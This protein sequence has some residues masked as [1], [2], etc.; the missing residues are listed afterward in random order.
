LSAQGIKS[1]N[2]KIQLTGDRRDST[3]PEARRAPPWQGRGNA[4]WAA[5]SRP[6][7]RGCAPALGQ[8]LSPWPSFPWCL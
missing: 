2:Q 8:G 7:G 1:R 4:A 3:L 5:F 6:Y